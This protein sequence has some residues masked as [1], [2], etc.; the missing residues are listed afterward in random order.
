MHSLWIQIFQEILLLVVQGVIVT[1]T[2]LLHRMTK[3]ISQMIQNHMEYLE[4]ALN[5]FS[6]T[7]RP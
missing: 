7:K 5:D 1:G 4:S 2:F 6:T 3:S